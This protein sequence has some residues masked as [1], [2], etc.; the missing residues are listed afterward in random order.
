MMVLAQAG[1]AGS[2][3]HLVI[4]A[5]IVAAVVGIGAIAI[6]ASGV[7]VPQWVISIFWIVV[8]ALVAIF[9]IRVV[10]GWV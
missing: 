2:V 1:L 5:I 8:I 9:A 7:S 3:A 4:L 10:M 6:R